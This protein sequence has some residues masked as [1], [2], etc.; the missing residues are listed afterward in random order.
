MKVTKRGGNIAGG[1]THKMIRDH[2]YGKDRS[3]NL[4]FNKTLGIDG[5]FKV[6]FGKS[7]VKTKPKGE[8]LFPCSVCLPLHL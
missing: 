3:I 1:Q 2:D 4:S 5:G 7:V 6:I 8:E